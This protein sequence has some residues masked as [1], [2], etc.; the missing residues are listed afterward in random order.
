MGTVA[1]YETAMGLAASL[2][3]S[4]FKDSI[5]GSM[6]RKDYTMALVVCGEAILQTLRRE[7]DLSVEELKTRMRNCSK[8]EKLERMVSVLAREAR[9]L[10]KERKAA[11]RASKNAAW[12]G[13][14]YSSENRRPTQLPE[15]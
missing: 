4:E 10:A 12:P 9:A 2:D 14:G 8:L 6:E 15:I 3:D 1:S 7:T 5:L 13:N 11:A